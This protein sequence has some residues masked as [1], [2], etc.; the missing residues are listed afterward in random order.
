[1]ERLS[2]VW[3]ELAAE[4]VSLEGDGVNVLEYWLARCNIDEDD[5]F[6]WQ[7]SAIPNMLED[8]HFIKL[9]TPS[10]ISALVSQ[11]FILGL[12]YGMRRMEDELKST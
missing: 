12:V 7:R 11:G 2:E 4:A 3:Y 8:E 9:D 6:D 1:M 5:F 10:K